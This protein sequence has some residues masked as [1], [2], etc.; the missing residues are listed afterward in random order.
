[1]FPKLE[2]VKLFLKVYGNICC[3]IHKKSTK[4]YSK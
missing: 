4:L 1:M 3:R 2:K